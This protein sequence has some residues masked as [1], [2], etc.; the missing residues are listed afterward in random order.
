MYLSEE[1]RAAIRKGLGNQNSNS[2]INSEK[3]ITSF[4]KGFRKTEGVRK[5]SHLLFDDRDGKEKFFA[6]S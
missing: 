3:N 6:T 4:I 2:N 5:V 1:K